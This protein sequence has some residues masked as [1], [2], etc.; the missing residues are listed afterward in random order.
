MAFQLYFVMDEYVMATESPC[1]TTKRLMYDTIMWFLTKS[2]HSLSLFVG[3][4]L[5]LAYRFSAYCVFI[6]RVVHDVFPVNL[7]C[8]AKLLPFGGAAIGVLLLYFLLDLVAESSVSSLSALQCFIF[9]RRRCDLET[10]HFVAPC[11]FRLLMMWMSCNWG[12]VNPGPFS[13]YF[14][15]LVLVFLVC[16]GFVATFSVDQEGSER[17]RCHPAEIGTRPRILWAF[18]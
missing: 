16:F 2:S 12:S 8:V 17:R 13:F 4:H 14:W 9:S 6:I 5:D 11:G 15:L 3:A 18:S 7:Y 1:P 10:R